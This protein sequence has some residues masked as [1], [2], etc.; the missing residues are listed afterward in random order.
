MINETLSDKI[1]NK[2][3][4]NK[5]STRN[6]YNRFLE[7][8]DVKEFIQKLDEVINNWA[9]NE[10][11]KWGIPTSQILLLKKRIKK[12]I[13][14]KKLTEN[15]IEPEAIKPNGNSQTSGSDNHSPKEMEK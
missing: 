3:D 14:G 13:F 11:E 4:I 2:F 12:D 1:T 8:K 7:V 15:H 10:E 5:F 6:G 9:Y